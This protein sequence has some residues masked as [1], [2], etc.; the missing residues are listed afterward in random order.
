LRVGCAAFTRHIKVLADGGGGKFVDGRA[1]CW[2][3]GKTR[4]G[5]G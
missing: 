2:R 4:L 3:D 1:K 5:L